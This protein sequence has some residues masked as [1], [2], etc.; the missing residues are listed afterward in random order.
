MSD[1]WS[2]TVLLTAST[3]SPRKITKQ[4]STEQ[5]SKLLALAVVTHMA[6]AESLS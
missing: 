4:V 6:E 2:H 5:Q 1:K 3:L